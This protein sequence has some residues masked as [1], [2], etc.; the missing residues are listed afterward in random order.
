MPFLG[1]SHMVFQI[2]EFRKNQDFAH[3]YG[4]QGAFLG[5]S[6]ARRPQPMH[7]DGVSLIFYLGAVSVAALFFIMTSPGFRKI[8]K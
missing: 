5:I 3:F 1:P 2:L 4:F 6:D 8:G 7:H